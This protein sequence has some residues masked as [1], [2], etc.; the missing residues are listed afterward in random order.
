MPSRHVYQE[1]TEPRRTPVS[2][3]R[4]V[5]WTDRHSVETWRHRHNNR[6]LDTTYIEKDARTSAYGNHRDYFQS[7]KLNDQIISIINMH[8]HTCAH[9]CAHT[10]T[11]THTLNFEPRTLKLPMVR[12]TMMAVF[13]MNPGPM[14]I[15]F[16]YDGITQKCLCLVRSPCVQCFLPQA[17]VSFLNSDCLLA[18]Q[19][20]YRLDVEIFS[21]PSKYI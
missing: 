10:H 13:W 1:Y 12:S 3:T 6:I 2:V 16:A 17:Q 20:F 8:A 11:H 5:C 14:A 4:L 15:N 21:T 9:T 7:I 18:E 19:V